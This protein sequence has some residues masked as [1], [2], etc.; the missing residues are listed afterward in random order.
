M[1]AVM[2]TA[3]TVPSGSTRQP[4]ICRSSSGASMAVPSQLGVRRWGTFAAR[5]PGLAADPPPLAHPTHLHPGH[6]P[7]G[8]QRL[9]LHGIGAVRERRPSRALL[10]MPWPPGGLKGRGTHCNRV[11]PSTRSDPWIDGA[12]SLTVRREGVWCPPVPIPLPV[13]ERAG[14]RP[15]RCD[16]AGRR[17]TLPCALSPQER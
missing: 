7:D 13:G 3:A 2:S 14:S 9:V 11:T 17:T 16:P 6:H 1:R 10:A 8:D 15:R 12:Q 4:A 5:C